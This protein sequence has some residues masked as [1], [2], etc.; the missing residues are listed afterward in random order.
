MWPK[1]MV[2]RQAQT[3]NLEGQEKSLDFIQNAIN[4]RPTEVLKCRV[5]WPGCRF[6]DAAGRT[7]QN[8]TNVEGSSKTTEAVAAA[9]KGREEGGLE[10]DMAK[11]AEKWM[12]VRSFLE[13]QE[14]RL[15]DGHAGQGFLNRLD[16]EDKVDYGTICLAMRA[17]RRIQF[18]AEEKVALCFK[19]K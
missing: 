1:L 19:K 6:V 13:A 10:L 18:E 16:L 9:I 12:E 4:W 15:A 8:R 14:I 17:Q 2:E 11:D 5:T 3:K 7:D